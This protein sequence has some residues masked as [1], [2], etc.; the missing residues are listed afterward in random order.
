[1][2][3]TG[4]NWSTGSKA[5]PSA[6]C[7]PQIPQ[8]TGLESKTSGNRPVTNHWCHCRA[9]S[10]G[11]W[12][13]K[14]TSITTMPTVATGATVAH[15]SVHYFNTKLCVQKAAAD[16]SNTDFETPADYWHAPIK[17]WTHNCQASMC[18]VQHIMSRLEGE[19][20]LLSLGRYNGC[21][22]CGA[23][24][25]FLVTDTHTHTH[26]QCTYMNWTCIFK[27]NANMFVYIQQ[28]KNCPHRI[29]CPTK[30]K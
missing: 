23:S 6:I 26:T 13:C 30:F 2:I 4:I 16:K 28:Y 1:M 8:E 7:W 22:V 11:K 20:Y 12:Q 25:Q 18:T 21:T 24:V 27:E 5:C 15:H 14:Q 3:L 19:R 29:F 17:Y 9:K 10:T